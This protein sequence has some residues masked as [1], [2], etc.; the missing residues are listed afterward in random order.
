MRVFVCG[1]RGGDEPGAGHAEM[2]EQVRAVVETEVEHF[3]FA[4]GGGEGAVDEF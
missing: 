2:R 3:A 4:M 1:P